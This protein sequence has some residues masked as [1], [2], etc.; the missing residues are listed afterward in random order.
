MVYR[1]KFLTLK[2]ASEKEKE[3][4]MSFI[5]GVFALFNIVAIL[6]IIL[7][8]KN[9]FGLD[10]KINWKW[11]W[12]ATGIYYG[13]SLVEVSLEIQGKVSDYTGMWL[14]WG[15]IL[16]LVLVFSKKHRIFNVLLALPALLTY[17]QW[18]Q[19]IALFEH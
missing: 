7:I 10:M 3:S 6:D 1:W 11:F 18:T 17:G 13:I 8:Q 19:T 12:I 16:L 2:I 5:E 9:L 4:S 14:T 15:Y